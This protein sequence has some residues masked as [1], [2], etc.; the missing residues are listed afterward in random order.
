MEAIKEALPNLNE[1]QF[2]GGEP[3]VSKD[4]EDILLAA[5][6]TGDNKHI[7]LEITTNGTKFVEEKLDI[8][9]QF[10]KIKFII[11]IDSV[12]STYDYI[13]Y[14]FSF[15]LIEKRL[16][17]IIDYIIKN[18]LKEKV[19]LHFACVGILYNLYDYE[20]LYNFLSDILNPIYEGNIDL[21]L[22]SSDQEIQ[23][24]KNLME[25]PTI[26]EKLRDSLEPQNIANYL[27]NLAGQFHRYYSM[28]RIVT[29]DHATTA[30]RL[31][32][33]K[34]LQIVLFN[35]FKVMGIHAPKRM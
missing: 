25:F 30:A 35:G 6:E 22:L 20:K 9:L 19:E 27:H 10:K 12:G 3:F 4:V 28:E 15:S 17:G 31:V 5:I 34:A 32:L 2:A 33:V 8:F 1:L 11:S 23:L 16:R 7:D 14:P 26:I 21:S 18:N 24:I 29:D 13:R